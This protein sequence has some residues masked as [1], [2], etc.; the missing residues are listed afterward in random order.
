MGVQQL[1]PYF[2]YNI[3]LLAIQEFHC[4]IMTQKRVSKRKL[5]RVLAIGMILLLVSVVLA[6]WGVKSVLTS[7]FNNGFKNTLAA[8]VYELKFK[9][10]EVNYFTGRIDILD[11]EMY[12]RETQLHHY[13]YINSS[14]RF[15]ARKIVLQNV[16]I[17]K[18]LFAK[19][20]DLDKIEIVE[21]DINFTIADVN[22]LFFP[23]RAIIL[24]R[25]E[26]DIKLAIDTYVI[27]DLSMIDAHFH[28]VNVAK[29]REYDIQKVNIAVKEMTIDREE[30]RD[31]I[32]Y[33][34]FDFSLGE[35]AGQ[36]KDK[37][38]RDIH[39]QDFKARMDSLQLDE[40]SDT[41]IYHFSNANTSMQ[42][43]DIET[44]DSLYHI[45]LE[46]FHLHYRD[47]T[48]DFT[49]FSFKP[50][51]SDQAMAR[52]YDYRKEV[53]RAKANSFHLTDMNF[54]SL[55]YAQ[56]LEVKEV[57]LDSVSG[58]IYKDLTKPFPPHH[59][60]KYLAQ[61]VLGYSIP[62]SIQHI[63]VNNANLV[64]TEVKPDG[65]IGK[66]NIKRGTLDI[67]NVTNLPTTEK[68]NIRADAF[69]ENTAHVYLKLEFN[70]D[71][72]QYSLDGKI[73][74]FEI[75]SLNPFI[76][77]YAPIRVTKGMVDGITFSGMVYN[78]YSSG[79][80]KCLYHDLS[81]D[82]AMK[83]NANLKTIIKGIVAKT[84]I[85]SSNPPSPNQPPRVVLFHFDR[86][87][88]TGF[89]LMIVR[90]VFDGVQE[91]LVMSKENKKLY[92]DKKAEF[93]KKEKE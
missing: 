3:A 14:F 89:I 42:N 75:P 2:I 9:K 52:R 11:V 10:L 4:S 63:K 41:L 58:S 57:L 48:G 44:A 26:K 35:F 85:N 77:S 8:E 59:R 80:M 56:K 24:N 29:L 79:T 81:F 47:K 28:V 36:L 69:L 7:T 76:N 64:N 19:K 54:D 25:E 73:E 87:M 67:E 31:K 51:I 92:Q 70:Y 30:G 50:N 38:L 15:V 6:F 90:S 66:A 23:F 62:V 12:P 16:G 84:V 49:K 91:T 93:K 17:V 40:T 74:P 43:L 68:L 22:L 21:P 45:T 88:R 60:P 39:F 83:D 72:S 82:M 61:Q 34:H 1:S 37:D 71:K 18:L 27:K 46:S 13:A 20:L 86:D 32:A 55:I 53:F 5:Y 78:T 65:S 33:Q